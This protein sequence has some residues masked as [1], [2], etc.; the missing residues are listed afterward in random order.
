MDS[1]NCGLKILGKKNSRKFQALCYFLSYSARGLSSDRRDWR[2]R[3]EQPCADLRTAFSLI[4]MDTTVIQFK[5]NSANTK[6]VYVSRSGE[7]VTEQDN[8]PTVPFTQ[9]KGSLENS[10]GQNYLLFLPNIPRDKER[11]QS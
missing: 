3:P 6:T 4:Q 9:F 7:T 11:H 8:W 2:K 10:S 5:I 1:T